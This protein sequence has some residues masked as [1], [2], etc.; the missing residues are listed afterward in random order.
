MY[1]KIE[2]GSYY[3]KFILLVLSVFIIFSGWYLNSLFSGNFGENLWRLALVGDTNFSINHNF[4]NNQWL[5]E[6]RYIICILGIFF[7]F[8]NYLIIPKLGNN[9][10]LKNNKVFKYYLKSFTSYNFNR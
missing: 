5:F 4:D 7:A 2:E 8:L 1:N 3:L 6:A 10:K 9:L